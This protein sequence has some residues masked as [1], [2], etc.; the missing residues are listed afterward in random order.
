MIDTLTELKN[1]AP[2]FGILINE[3]KTKYMECIT[4][5]VRGNNLEIYSMSC[6]SVQYCNRPFGFES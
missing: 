4:K 3:N 6:Q 1:E 5:Q 2:K